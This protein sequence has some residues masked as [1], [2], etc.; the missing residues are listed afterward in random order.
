MPSD[1]AEAPAGG[2]W[3]PAQVGPRAFAL[4]W[5]PSLRAPRAF[6]WHSAQRTAGRGASWGALA[7][8]WQATHS[9]RAWTE[10]L[11][12]ASSTKRESERPGAGA[13][14]FNSRSPWHARHSWAVGAYAARAASGGRGREAARGRRGA[15]FLI[16]AEP[17]F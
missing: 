8:L 15:P 9:R 11:A 2:P 14:R 10:A 13:P 3:R 12:A 7:V 1:A 16:A 6:A 4:P 5:T 17:D